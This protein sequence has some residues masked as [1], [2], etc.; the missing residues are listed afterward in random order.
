MKLL[1][2]NINIKIVI[3]N[4]LLITITLI[5]MSIV[6]NYTNQGL[7]LELHLNNILIKEL[8][9]MSNIFVISSLLAFFINRKF[10]ILK[11][12]YLFTLMLIILT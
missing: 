6:L 12:I 11:A 3:A 1:I 5:L 9:L 2:K 10:H 8:L 4:T 7:I